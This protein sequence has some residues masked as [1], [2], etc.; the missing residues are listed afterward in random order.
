[1]S[2]LD[3]LT[4]TYARSFPDEFAVEASSA[5]RAELLSLLRSLPTELAVAIIARLSVN[6][7]RDVCTELKTQLGGWLNGAGFDD[8]VALLIRLPRKEQSALVAA[9]TDHGLRRR[10]R[11]FLNFPA[12]SVGSLAI[13]LPMRVSAETPLTEVLQ[14]LKSLGGRSETPVVVIGSQGEYSGVLDVWRLL[15]RDT[16]AGRVRDFNRWVNPVLPELS[17]KNAR[18]LPQWLQHNWLPVVDHEK[19]VLGFVRRE[20]ILGMREFEVSDAEIV[21]ESIQELGVRYVVVLAQLLERV[22]G[23]AGK[24]R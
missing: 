6:A 19:R 21:G 15:T 22:L 14:E 9:V 2:E 11:Q 1:M 20:Q 4:L 18:T 10:L 13:E 16:D 23:S 3:Q 7:F 24:P 5:P 17:L 12:H 8:N